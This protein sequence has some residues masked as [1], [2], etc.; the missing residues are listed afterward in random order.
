MVYAD[1]RYQPRETHQIPLPGKN[2][3]ELQE[4]FLITNNKLEQ[5]TIQNLADVHR[6]SYD[7]VRKNMSSLIPQE[8]QRE[9]FVVTLS[10]KT[11]NF[12]TGGSMPF[13]FA[14]GELGRRNLRRKNIRITAKQKVSQLFAKPHTLACNEFL[15]KGKLLADRAPWIALASYKHESEL[16][17][18]PMFVSVTPRET[19]GIAPDLWMDFH[20]FP[21]KRYCFSVEINLT[22]VTEK[23]WREKIRGYINCVVVYKKMF[24]TDI[25]VVP[26]VVSTPDHFPKRIYPVFSKGQLSI[27]RAQTHE[28]SHRLKNLILWTQREL[29]EQDA[30]DMAD[31]FRFTEVA[32]DQ[33]TPQELFLYPLWLM[34]FSPTPV[35]LI[36]IK[37]ET[38]LA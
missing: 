22:E 32:L 10:A 11:R 18:S 25:I 29:K 8:E 26:V 33:I 30:K 6:L 13:V 23:V 9:S 36:S 37:E 31:M 20:L 14:L 3:T 4:K 28:R 1:T 17:Q 21:K 5:V 7:Y 16:K 2:V 27:R 15:I 34:P 35:P 24:G 19:I 38:Q 12:Q